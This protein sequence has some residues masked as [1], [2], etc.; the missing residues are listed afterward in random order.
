MQLVLGTAAA[1]G[2]AVAAYYLQPLR[3][4][5]R[6]RA[7]ITLKY[8]NI[9]GLG[10]PIRLALAMAGVSFEDH[11]FKERSEF[12]ALKPS[13]TFG[14]VPALFVDGTEMVQSAAVMRYIGQALDPSGTLYPS[15]PVVAQKVDAMADQVKD[16]VTGRLVYK[17]K[18]R[19]GFTAEVITE[20][21]EKTIE[22]FWFKDTLPRHLGFFA[23]QLVE[24]RPGRSSDTTS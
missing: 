5:K 10:E 12:I 17:Y 4:L 1:I 8:F 15:D 16:M 6:A 13:L 3:R 9:D 7:K 24:S 11:R 2:A 22:A 14:Q 19:Y 20:D 21:V 18:E 23:A